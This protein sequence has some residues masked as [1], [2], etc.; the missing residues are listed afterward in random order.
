MKKDVEDH[1]PGLETQVGEWSFGA[2][3]HV[4]GAL[5]VAEALGRFAEAGLDHAF[6]WTRPKKGSPA[7]AAFRAFANYDGAGARFAG[8]FVPTG[9]VPSG[10]S[11]FVAHDAVA[12]RYAAIL[13]RFQGS[14]NEEIELLLDDAACRSVRSPRT[15]RLDGRELVPENTTASARSVTVAMPPLSLVLVEWET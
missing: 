12:K 4:S 9:A 15:F 5:A 3:R 8:R 14:G 10:Y 7:E 13:L 6:Y 1:Y 11:V 2:E